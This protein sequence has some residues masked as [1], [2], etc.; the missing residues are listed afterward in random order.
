MKAIKS[1]TGKGKLTATQKQAEALRL[2]TQG[3]PLAEI[4]RILGYRGESGAHRAIRTGLQKTLQEPADELRTMEAERLDRMLEG[5]WDKAVS[6]DTW[7]VDRVLGIMDRRA[8]LLG[9]DKSSA[10]D[11]AAGAQRYL[12]LYNMAVA[13]AAD[14]SEAKSEA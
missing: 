2:R 6:G 11:P 3:K 9:L 5:L 1:A 13:D 7:S 14:K 12:D 4:A 10:D 8:K